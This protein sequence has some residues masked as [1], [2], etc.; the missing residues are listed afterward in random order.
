M[1]LKLIFLDFDGVLHPCTA[2]TFVYVDRFVAFLRKHPCI[3]VVFSTSWRLDHGWHDLL[4]L[5]PA[6][7]HERFVGV[8]PQLNDALPAVREQEILAWLRANGALRLDWVALDD[9]VSLFTAFCAQ[10]VRC[11]TVRGLRAT[12]LAQIE[13]KFGMPT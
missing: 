8:T 5:F 11:E 13:A 7:L 6:D 2:G 4:A 12:Q 3:R 9:D 1:E 10:L